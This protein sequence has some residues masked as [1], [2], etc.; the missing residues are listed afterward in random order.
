MT[1]LSESELLDAVEGHLPS[2]RLRHASQCPRCGEQVDALRVVLAR[3]ADVEV[4]EPS[5]LFWDHLAARVRESIQQEAPARA[6]WMSVLRPWPV[7]AGAAA[8]LTVMAAVN[9][10]WRPPSSGAPG[11]LEVAG[12]VPTSD[13][14]ADVT[15]TATDNVEVDEAWALVRAI[16]EDV[17]WEDVTGAGISARPGSAER[18]V[19]DLTETERGEL[20]ALIEEELRRAGA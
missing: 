14:S 19:M 7:A 5:P 11:A 15:R 1:H 13:A 17:L 10:V 20:A 18:A 16:A 8:V 2:A 6:G 9:A 12:N 3:T 4:P